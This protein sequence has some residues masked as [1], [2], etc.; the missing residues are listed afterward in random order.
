[1]TR[2]FALIRLRLIHSKSDGNRAADDRQIL[3]MFDAVPLW[4]IP[5]WL[6]A[7]VL[8]WAAEEGGNRQG[9]I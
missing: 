8:H 9:K 3:D 1:M 7:T 4:L 2:Y 5:R 6:V